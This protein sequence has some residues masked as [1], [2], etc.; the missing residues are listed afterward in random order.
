[1]KCLLVSQHEPLLG[2][3]VG[4]IL[5]EHKDIE[6]VEVESEDEVEIDQAI[7]QLRPEVIILCRPRHDQECPGLE[8]TITQHPEVKWIV[9][10]ADNNQV[11]VYNKTK[12]EMRFDR[13]AELIGVIRGERDQ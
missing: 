9:V 3:A 11:N 6:V 2:S 1:M 10:N 5:S 4:I 8:N 7:H 13:S 12:K